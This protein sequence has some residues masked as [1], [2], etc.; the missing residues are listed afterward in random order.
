MAIKRCEKCGRRFKYMDVL[1]SIGWGYR[2]LKCDS[3]GA[4]HKMEIYHIFIIAGLLIAPMFFMNQIYQVPLT[5]LV[6][7][8]IALLYIIYMTLIIGL[9]PF[10][11]RYRLEDEREQDSSHYIK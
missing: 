10:I 2:S 11:I 9:Y 1:E 4:K 5:M 7:I 3:C 6:R 8:V